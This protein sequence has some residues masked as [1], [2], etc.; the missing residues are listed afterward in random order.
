MK[1]ILYLPLQ[2]KLVL[3]FRSVKGKPTK[4]FG[5]FQLWGD[6]KDNI[7]AIAIMP[8]LEELEEFEKTTNWIQL[9]GIWKGIDITEEDI[10]EVRQEWLSEL[11]K[12][13][14]EL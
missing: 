14:E 12:E 1:V 11:E 3:M 4:E 7:C 8:F 5:R 2:D 13:W 9:G 6:R 10:K